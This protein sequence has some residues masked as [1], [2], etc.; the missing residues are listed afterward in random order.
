MDYKV[1]NSVEKSIQGFSGDVKY[2]LGTSVVKHYKEINHN[3][4]LSIPP[5]PSHLETVDP[6][7][8]GT[9]RSIQDLHHDAERDR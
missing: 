6:V 9:A 3:I 4:K 1:L 7:L 5:N 2:H 8:Y